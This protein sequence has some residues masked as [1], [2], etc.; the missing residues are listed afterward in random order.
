MGS[1][2]HRDL[3]KPSASTGGNYFEA[4]GNYECLIVGW[5]KIDTMKREAALVVDLKIL[6]ADTD[7]Y[8]IGSIRNFF[9]GEGHVLFDSKVKNLLVAAMGLVD[10]LDAE[11]IE[12]E[13]WYEVLEASIKPPLIFLRRKINVLVSYDIKGDGKKKLKKSPG[14]ED[15]PD[16]LK[17]YQFT[18][19]DFS[20]HDE[21]RNGTLTL[22]A[23]GKAK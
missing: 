4:P 19:V 9:L 16:F 1:F 13:N 5:K 6:S 18:K 8:P 7:A 23:A 22:K 20:A 12:T 10:G 14:M 11:K 21:T 3:Q 2:A 15:D 17:E